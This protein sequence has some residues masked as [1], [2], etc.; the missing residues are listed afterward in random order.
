VSTKRRY[1]PHGYIDA[2]QSIL[3][4][5]KIRNP[6][7]WQLEKLHPKEILIYEGL[8]RTHRGDMLDSYLT[9]EIP[10][11]DREELV[12]GLTDRYCDYQDALMDLRRTLHLG[13]IK[14]EFVDEFGRFG[15]IVQSV[16][17]TD[18]GETFLES[19]VAQLNDGPLH[20]ISR[21][22]LLQEKQIEEFARDRA[23]G[24]LVSVETAAQPLVATQSK[25]IRPISVAARNQKFREWRAGCGENTPSYRQD[26]DYMAQFDVSR[27]AVRELRKQYPRLLRGRPK[28]SGGE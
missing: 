4:I 13:T 9:I 19:G 22:I 3:K 17:G 27:D 11:R 10:R 7:R 25:A 5:A 24:A 21:L 16:W 2:E 8:G 28:S 20:F 23:V 6:D 12:E 26:V 14:G 1:I 18:E 15:C